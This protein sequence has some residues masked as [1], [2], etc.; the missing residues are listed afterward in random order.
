M[1]YAA[2]GE[3]HGLIVQR[4]R[5][6]RREAGKKRP[7][8]IRY[9]L[10]RLTDKG[11]LRRQETEALY[12]LANIGENA[13][14]I[15]DLRRVRR[16]HQTFLADSLTSP[17]AVVLSGIVKDSLVTVVALENDEP[18][19][20]PDSSGEDLAGAVE[21]AVEGSGF[22]IIGAIIGAVVVGG[23]ASAAVEAIDDDDDD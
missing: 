7:D 16:I 14:R 1:S 15:S 12:A 23:I 10:N 11:L 13:V 22:G 8:R 5:T 2:L 4:V 21:G 19:V 6:A 3:L 9:N 18:G 20:E 17:L